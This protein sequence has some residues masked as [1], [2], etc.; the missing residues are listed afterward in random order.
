MARPV[1]TSEAGRWLKR[2]VTNGR[3]NAGQD[4]ESNEDKAQHQIKSAK[5]EERQ[6]GDE[7]GSN[8]RHHHS[9][10]ELIKSFDVRD[11]S[12]QQITAVIILQARGRERLECRE[13]PDAQAG[14]NPKSGQV[15]DVPL[16]IA[17]DGADNRKRPHRGNRDGEVEEARDERG[18]GNQVR[19][20]CHQADGRAEGAKSQ[21]HRQGKPPPQRRR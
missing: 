2:R 12:G 13:K 3:D 6:R 9:H 10:I 1:M 5:N 11:N 8:R 14:E 19:R 16:R 15:R 17:E 21:K 7:S 20:H 4:Q 18:L